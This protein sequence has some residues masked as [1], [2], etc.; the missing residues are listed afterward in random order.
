VQTYVYSG[1]S[2]YFS[3]MAKISVSSKGLKDLNPINKINEAKEAIEITKELFE[4]QRSTYD[5]YKLN[6]PMTIDE[7]YVLLQERWTL[8]VTY[9]M[10]KYWIK[11]LSI[12]EFEPFLGAKP[13][14]QKS[15]NGKD[16]WFSLN[17][18][19]GEFEVSINKNGT[20]REQLDEVEK[21]MEPVYQYYNE[22]RMA[23]RNVLSDK[24]KLWD[25]KTREF[26]EC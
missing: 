4:A 18:Q 11:F 24:A 7:L 15:V 17:F 25:W 14:L 5:R 23:I 26:R 8:P 2:L 10:K 16:V 3:N 22:L 13:S 21:A 12:I 20:K 19:A 1:V 6:E 9:K